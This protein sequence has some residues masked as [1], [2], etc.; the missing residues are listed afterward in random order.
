MLASGKNAQPADNI[1]QLLR[2]DKFKSRN[3]KRKCPDVGA[4]IAQVGPEVRHDP[5]SVADWQ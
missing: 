1:S 3:A 5:G 4:S 2:C